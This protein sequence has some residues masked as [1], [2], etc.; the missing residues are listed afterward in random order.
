MSKTVP[1]TAA[2]PAAELSRAALVLADG[3]C[4]EG[5]G[6]GA[7]AQAVGEVCFNTAMTGYEEML[8]DPSYAGQIVCFTF[9]HIGIVGT[10]E[11]DIES[12]NPAVR[13]LIVRADATHP[14]NWRNLATLDRW[15]K[16][17]NIPAIA[18]IDTR[19]RLAHPREGHAAWRDRARKIRCCGID[20]SGQGIL[21]PR[22]SRSRERGDVT[23]D[24]QVEPD[25]VAARQRLWRANQTRIPRRRDRLR[26]QA[27]HP[28]RARRRRRGHHRRARERDARRRDEAQAA[29]R[30]A[31]QRS[32][33][34]GGDGRICDCH[35]QR[36][37]GCRRAGVRDLPR[38]SDARPRARRPRPRR[39]RRAITAPTIR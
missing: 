1:A 7:E 6:F 13:G 29:R 30:G 15:L 35:D 25:A 31:V 20:E 3:T 12:I 33:R 23:P 11:E 10:N 18:G 26:R 36:I 21:R 22:R 16:R 39:W 38:P 4:F 2:S 28:A 19:A 9:P 37:D 24:E 27:Q 17:H 5:H 34:S 8:S 32:R 14:S